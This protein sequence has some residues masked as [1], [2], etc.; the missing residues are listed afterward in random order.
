MSYKWIERKPRT[1]VNSGTDLLTKLA[2]ARGIKKEEVEEHLAPNK[3]AL[4]PAEEMKNAIEASDRIKKAIENDEKILI[5]A[6][7]DADGVTSTAIIIRYLRERM[8]K[9][10]PYIF[11]ER[12][13][14][15]GIEN[16][17]TKKNVEDPDN[18]ERNNN[19]ENNIKLVKEADL[20]IIVDSSSN[21]INTIDK[22][23]NEYNTDVIVLDHHALNDP[24]KTPN[25]VGAIL[26]NPQQRGC[27]YINKNL[28]GAGVVYKIVGL[29]ERMFDDGLIEAE[30]YIDLAG[31]GVYA[32]MMPMDEPEN[33]YI[34]SQA[35]LNIHNMGLERILKSA[36]GVNLNNLSGDTIGFTIAPL[37]NGTARMGNIQDAIELLLT[38][39]DKEVKRIRLRMHRAN[40]ERKTMQKELAE[41]LM[42]D[43]D[44]SG[45][46]IFVVTDK[47]ASGF[48]GLIA[49]DIAQ[50]YQ[51]PVFVGRLKNGEIH[52]SARTYGGVK[53]KTFFEDSGLVLYASGHEGALGIGFKES[54]FDLIKEYVE[55]HGESASTVERIMYYDIHLDSTEVLDS[56]DL[57]ESF[58]HIT[59]IN[60]PKILVRV[61]DLMVNERKVLGANLNTVKFSTMDEIDLIKFRVDEEYADEV[62]TMDT[63]S[64]VGE[65]K[66]NEWTKFRPV[67]EV[68]RTI[69]VMINDYKLEE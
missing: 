36:K 51:K 59:G 21:D 35:L 2:N 7:N 24:K 64:V 25:D 4:L 53:L 60:C 41:E 62:G 39:E 31:V 68:I 42:Q 13:W 6:D 45:K 63:I 18:E 29:I 65:L 69:Q 19:A 23:V 54:Q 67:Y 15:H 57:I 44:H 37:I 3:S 52:G 47:S 5:S 20:L 14:G 33:R 46:M 1:S 28:S 48:N 56:I 66:W 8:D 34:V 32:D 27:R 61:D 17:L 26:V 9:E 55:E 10:I 30:K 16:Q 38:D 50:K 11:A 22:I 58:N 12:D 49:Q 43:V 40:E